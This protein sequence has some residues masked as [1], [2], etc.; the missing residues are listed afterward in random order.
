[1]SRLCVARPAERVRVDC[2]SPRAPAQAKWCLALL[3]RADSS[4][5]ASETAATRV[6]RKRAAT[7]IRR[8]AGER[9]EVTRLASDTLEWLAE[10]LIEREQKHCPPP[11][12]AKYSKPVHAAAHACVVCPK[13]R[14]PALIARFDALSR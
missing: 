9:E 13:E 14:G 1:M 7:A 3:S 5:P 10:R 6:F 12:S 8:T 4:A 11:C 2:V